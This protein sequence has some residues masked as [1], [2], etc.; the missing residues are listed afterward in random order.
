MKNTD[1]YHVIEFDD[2]SANQRANELIKKDWVLL[3]VGT[4]TIDVENN[5]AYYNTT[6]VLG[7]TKEQYEEYENK[8]FGINDLT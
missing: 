4:K 6:Y 5:Q 8:K 1:F 3:H 2:D 7:G